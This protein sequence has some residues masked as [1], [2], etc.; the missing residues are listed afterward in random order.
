MGTVS[1]P[2][3]TRLPR[4][5]QGT[6][7]LGEDRRRRTAEI[8]AL[9]EGFALGLTLV[10][11]AEFY[12]LG[13]AE[14]VVG[15]AVR[16]CRERVFVVTKIWPTHYEPR[17]LFAALTASL[18]RLGTDHVDAV[19]LHWPSTAVPLAET[20]GALAE[21]RRQ[22][23][24]RYI[25]VSNFDR[26]WLRAAQATGVD[27]A[28]DEVP[29]SLADRRVEDD[30]LAP[31]QA[32]GVTVL[33]YSPLGHGRLRRWLRHPTVA[34]LAAALGLPPAALLL[35]YVV[36][37]EG[38]VALPKATSLEHVRQNARALDVELPADARA[39]LAA[40]LPGR[41]GAYRPD[42]PPAGWLFTLAERWFQLRR[43]RG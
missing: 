13:G 26:R 37:Q 16:D 27:I 22:G 29:Y 5:G 4:L 41:R 12:G 34:R 11:T 6:W 21:A 10:D 15:E 18:R 43:P 1:L 35:A 7:G 17:R 20:L 8:D 23:L 28:F 24:T 9:R 40:A 38:V 31:C 25:G 36:A 14:E 3:G 2:D 30:L 39:E 42:L 33:A 19:L 32:Q